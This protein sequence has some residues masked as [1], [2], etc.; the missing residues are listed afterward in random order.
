MSIERIGPLRVMVDNWIYV[1]DDEIT[2]EGFERS[3][4]N[5]EGFG[6][7][8]SRFPYSK[9]HRRP[10]KMLPT[11]EEYRDRR[12][13]AMEEWRHDLRQQRLAERRGIGATTTGGTTSTVAPT[14]VTPVLTPPID[15]SSG[16]ATPVV[17][18]GRYAGKHVSYV[19]HGHGGHLATMADQT[20]FYAKTVLHFYCA[21]GE[22][23]Q[24]TERRNKLN[25]PTKLINA[26]LTSQ[27]DLSRTYESVT[28]KQG[29]EPLLLVGDADPHA[30][31]HQGIWFVA[32]ETADAAPFECVRIHT[33]SS[34]KTELFPTLLR[35][36][37]IPDAR[38]RA[39][40]APLNIF[41][42]A[43]RASVGAGQGVA[44]AG[45]AAG[46]ASS[47]SSSSSRP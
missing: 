37:I 22:T 39:L 13:R 36:V 46:A 20:F 15:I 7:A 17:P 5:G 14:I 43:C 25:A 41:W 47:S 19:A 6:F 38:S 34:A 44:A 10:V 8:K 4:R 24:H 11:A 30:W 2:A 26:L 45:V 12:R 3:L 16:L 1:F 35:E 18:T 21:K 9:N 31:P 29:C 28:A 23:T 40:K 27:A 32:R 33:I 42:V